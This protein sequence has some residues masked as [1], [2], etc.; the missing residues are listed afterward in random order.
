MVVLFRFL[1]K[2]DFVYE[3]VY[4]DLGWPWGDKPGEFIL[5][6]ASKAVEY[7]LSQWC[8][9]IIVPPLVEVA[10]HHEW[11]YKEIVLPLWM[12]YARSCLEASPVG[13]IWFAGE[14]ADLARKEAFEKLFDAYTPTLTQQQRVDEIAKKKPSHSWSISFWWYEITMRK[15]YLTKLSFKSQIVHHSMKA[16]WRYFKDAAVD[17]IIPTNYGFFAYEAILGKFLNTKKQRFHGLAEVEKQFA[18]YIQNAKWEEYTVVISYTWTLDLLMREKKWI[19]LL[20]KGKEISMETKKIT[21]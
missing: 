8:E 9:K 19:W 21:L 20:Q 1:T 5:E 6:R 3:I 17:T 11:K 12:S 16:D 14:Y 4:D 18:T 13:K 15:Y 10:F 2:Y 7:L